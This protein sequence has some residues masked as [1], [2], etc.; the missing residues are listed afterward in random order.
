MTFSGLSF[1]SK[2]SA[3]FW[4]AARP[5]F[6][7]GSRQQR[8]ADRYGAIKAPSPS[9][10]HGCP[11]TADPGQKER[12]TSQADN[13]ST[14]SGAPVHIDATLID[15]ERQVRDLLTEANKVPSD[16]TAAAAVKQVWVVIDRMAATAA[17]TFA[18]AAC[19]LRIVLDPEVGLAAGESGKEIPMLLDDLAVVERLAD[20]A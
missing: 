2:Q 3:T 16:N 6:D 19:K 14:D 8:L 9:I 10:G 15:A 12:T 4:A 13:D 20:N 18:G 5:M 7:T 1:P 11:A 17:N